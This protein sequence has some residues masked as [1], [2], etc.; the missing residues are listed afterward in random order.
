MSEAI[1]VLVSSKDP[2]RVEFNASFSQMALKNKVGW[3]AKAFDKGSLAKVSALLTKSPSKPID[4]CVSL[5]GDVLK[6]FARSGSDR[7]VSVS[8]LLSAIK[9]HDKRLK[10]LTGLKGYGVTNDAL[11][12]AYKERD[13]MD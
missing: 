3:D 10:I 8:Q 4:Y 9:P 2:G 13:P 11:I 7:V 1:G 12:N 5:D 6:Y